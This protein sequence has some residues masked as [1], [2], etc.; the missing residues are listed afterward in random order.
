M[1][2]QRASYLSQWLVGGHLLSSLVR[3][4]R[5]AFFPQKNNKLAFQTSEFEFDRGSSFQ[6]IQGWH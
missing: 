1:Q 3:G 5:A 6:V 2:L 4:G